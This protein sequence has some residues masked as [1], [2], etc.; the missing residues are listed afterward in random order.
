VLDWSTRP[1]GHAYPHDWGPLLFYWRGGPAHFPPS[2]YLWPG[3]IDSTEAGSWV[4]MTSG[5]E[6]R[7]C[8]IGELVHLSDGADS[9][10]N[11]ARSPSILAVSRE[12]SKPAISGLSPSISARWCAA[13]RF[14]VGLC[15]HRLPVD[16]PNRAGDSHNP[17]EPRQP[18]LPKRATRQR[19]RA[20]LTFGYP[21]P[22]LS[23]F[24]IARQRS[25][26]S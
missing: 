17:L 10:G 22:T 25:R 1:A 6:R 24:I 4:S 13:L 8:V 14:R 19:Y 3:L 21:H 11:R 2:I 15:L 7:I 5:P 23:Q 18:P 16:D 9:K 20:T 26:R 12:V